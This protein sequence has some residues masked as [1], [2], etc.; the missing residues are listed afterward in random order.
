MPIE[1]LIALIKKNKDK[2]EFGVVIDAIEK[3][4]H[5]TPSRFTNGSNEKPLVNE[6]GTNEG[7]CK[8]FYF[9]KLNQLNQEEAL[10]CFGKY[11]RDDVLNNP[12]GDDHG[13]IRSFM[14]YG[15]DGINFE[16]AALKEK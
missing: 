8:I 3:H 12:D 9:S 7:S 13:N 5:Y 16:K 11:Y 2:I 14:T 10:A 1:E 4:Y 6:A 15:W